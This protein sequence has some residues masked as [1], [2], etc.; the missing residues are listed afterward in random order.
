ME[1]PI[2]DPWSI[3]ESGPEPASTERRPRWRSPVGAEG[4]ARSWPAPTRLTAEPR[5]AL[6]GHVGALN[7]LLMP[8]LMR[9]V[10]RLE[11]ARHQTRVDDRLDQPTPSLRLRMQPWQAPLAER[12]AGAEAVLE[13]LLDPGP[14][15]AITGRFWIDPPSA[16]PTHQTRVEATKLTGAWVDRLLLDF[17]EKALRQ[18]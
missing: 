14:A 7:A 12:H 16:A 13:I 15:P 2:F 6:S 5:N 9:L 18:G 17:V 1:D 10:H 3:R 8:R 4:V 11:M